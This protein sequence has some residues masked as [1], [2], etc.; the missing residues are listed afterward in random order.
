MQNPAT[1]VPSP[2]PLTE[3]QPTSLEAYFNLDPADMS[4]E[5]MD[6]IIAALRKDRKDFM[7]AEAEGKKPPRKKTPMPEGGLELEDLGL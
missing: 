2:S 6:I 7:Q 4:D 3:A 1:T 5:D